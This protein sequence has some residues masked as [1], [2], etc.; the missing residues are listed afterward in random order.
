MH[1]RD[2]ADTA[3]APNTHYG[4]LRCRLTNIPKIGR[5][6]KIAHK[7]VKKVFLALA[8]GKFVGK[9]QS[10]EGIIALTIEV[11]DDE[12]LPSSLKRSTVANYAWD[13]R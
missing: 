10:G 12:D 4:G 9:C 2:E 8:N 6:R 5:V 11:D 7:G 3:V 13:Q 1:D